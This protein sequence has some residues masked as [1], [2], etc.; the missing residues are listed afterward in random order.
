VIAAIRDEESYPPDLPWRDAAT[1]DDAQMERLK[2]SKF[3]RKHGKTDHRAQSLANRLGS[4]EA[5]Q[6]CLSG[7]CP[8]CG[9]LFQRWFVRFSKTFI[10]EHIVRPGHDLVAVSIVPWTP[11]P[12]LGQ[13]H[14]VGVVNLQRRLKDALKKA[15]LD[16]ALGAI[17]FSYNEDCNEKYLPFWCPHFYLIISTAD[18]KTLGKR[19]RKSFLKCEEIS[20]PVKISRFRNNAYRRSYALKMDFRRRVGYD[21]R[22]DEGQSRRSRKPRPRRQRLRAAERLELFGYLDKIGLAGRIIFLGGK[23]V[24]SSSRVTIE[25]C[26]C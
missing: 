26:R 3:L 15:D 11:A 4:C 17:D 5:E 20:R 25:R 8:E 12:G 14:T 10:S 22:G 23:P 16:V 2:R 24:V 7:A 13:L 1:A 6:R 18:K 19:L 21:G 9:R